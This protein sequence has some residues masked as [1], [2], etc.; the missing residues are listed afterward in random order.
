[1]QINK[2]FF[3]Y[4]KNFLKK[5]FVSNKKNPLKYIY[6]NVLKSYNCING[7]N[8]SKT[9]HNDFVSRVIL[10]I[11]N[12]L[13]IFVIICCR[14]GF[15]NLYCCSSWNVFCFEK[16]VRKKSESFLYLSEYFVIKNCF[17]VIFYGNFSLNLIFNS[18]ISKYLDS[19]LNRNL[20][21]CSFFEFNLFNFN[22]NFTTSFENDLFHNCSNF[23]KNNFCLNYFL[24]SIFFRFKNRIFLYFF[25]CMSDLNIINA[26][27]NIIFCKKIY[28]YF[29]K[30]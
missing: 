27:F 7:D 2:N 15:L 28:R 9:Y 30:I 23:L 13:W 11:C 17:N 19:D 26:D 4:L 1:M 3:L 12:S 8:F 14:R 16:W 5:Y 29:T 18:S 10:T 21:N 24:L 22:F 25:D 20:F 6:S